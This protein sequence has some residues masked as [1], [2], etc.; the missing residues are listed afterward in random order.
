MKYLPASLPG[1]RLTNEYNAS[2]VAGAPCAYCRGCRFA[3]WDDATSLP[4]HLCPTFL[5]VNMKGCFFG[6]NW[7]AWQ[8]KN[9]SNL[10]LL[11]FAFEDSFFKKRY[12]AKQLT[13][14]L[15]RYSQISRTL[16]SSKLARF[17]FSIS[18]R[19]TRMY[20]RVC[21]P[22]HGGWDY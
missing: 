19:A 18:K 3:I 17:S 14:T 13:K 10:T 1:R 8:H 16:V 21:S 11:C 4:L 20:T 7:Y 2:D 5:T 6:S 15:W 22:C 9:I 12:R